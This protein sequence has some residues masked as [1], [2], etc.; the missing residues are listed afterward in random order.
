MTHDLKLTVQCD[1][2]IVELKHKQELVKL[3][4]DYDRD[5]ELVFTVDHDGEP[6]Y[7]KVCESAFT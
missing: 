7:T 3:N 5:D 6:C 1:S 2:K 4:E